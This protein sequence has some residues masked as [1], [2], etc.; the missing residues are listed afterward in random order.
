MIE[1]ALSRRLDHPACALHLQ[2]AQQIGDG[3]FV[4][5][6]G[7]SGAGK[8]TVLRML[9]GLHRP[10]T[11][12]IVVDGVVWFDATAGINLPPQRRSVG[13]VFQDYALFPNLSVRANVGYGAAAGANRWVDDLLAMMQ[14]TGLQHQLPATLSGGQ[15]QRVALARAVARKPTL[16]LLDE[17]LAALDTALRLQ[18]QDDLAQLHRQ[19]GVKTLMVTHDIGE[20]FRLADV[21]WRLASGRVDA[22]GTPA[23]VFLQPRVAGRLAMRA[24]VLAMRREEVVIIV[25]LLIGQEIVDIIAVDADV[26]GVRVGDTVLLSPKGFDAISGALPRPILTT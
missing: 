12:R 3:A 4:A 14:L 24:Q 10:D 13:V 19:L 18:L 8:T 11:G 23:E 22:A 16:L 17:P 21:V 6:F 26:A 1:I 20:V 7:P 5:L 9:A 2:L 25:S 15:K